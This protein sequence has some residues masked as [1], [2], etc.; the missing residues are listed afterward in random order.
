MFAEFRLT[1]EQASVNAGEVDGLF[2]FITL[3]TA[4]FTLVIAV[5]IIYFAVKYRRRPDDPIPH[6]VYGSHRLEVAWIVPP[7]LIGLVIFFW[8]ASVYFSQATPPDDALEIYV[9]GRQWMWK[10]QHPDGQ[11]EINALHI[12]VG[13]PVKLTMISEDVIHSFFVP[14]FR[15]KQDVLPGRYTTSWFEATRTGRFRLY[16][17]EYCGTDH[18]RM[19]GWVEVMEPADYERWLREHAEGSPALEGAKLFRKLKCI[20]CHG[21]GG[22]NL[23]PLLEN[24]YRSD[25]RLTDGSTVEADNEYLRESILNP[26]KRVVAGYQKIMPTYKG[27]VSEEEILQL[28]AFIRSLGTGDT[29]PRVEQTEPPI[30]QPGEKMP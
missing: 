8:G 6:P 22:E 16:C 12:P 10:L 27:Q 23:A 5:S 13:Q 28:Q 7:V 20:S 17:T 2:W 21:R 15:T 18:S 3:V 4:F 24:I 11:R 29:P 26:G 25:V 30:D 9:V 14:A 1:P 19:I